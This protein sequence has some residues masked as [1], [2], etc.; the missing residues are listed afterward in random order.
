MFGESYFI[1]ANSANFISKSFSISSFYP[2]RTFRPAWYSTSWMGLASGEDNVTLRVAVLIRPSWTSDI[3]SNCSSTLVN[4]AQDKAFPGSTLI[5]SLQMLLQFA[6]FEN[7]FSWISGFEAACTVA[8]GLRRSSSTRSGSVILTILSLGEQSTMWFGICTVMFARL[9]T[10]MTKWVL[11][12]ISIIPF[13]GIRHTR[14]DTTCVGSKKSNP[15]MLDTDLTVPML[16]GSRQVR[17]S[18]RC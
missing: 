5:I 11:S 16:C 18:T 7:Q 15:V 17:L 1:C 6:A 8:T 3:P 4:L 12:R 14:R 9:A 10:R 13:P 2:F